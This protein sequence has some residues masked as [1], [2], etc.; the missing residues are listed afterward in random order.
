MAQ[1]GEGKGNDSF[2]NDKGTKEKPFSRAL[3]K[4]RAPMP[5]W[6]TQ[7][8]PKQSSAPR[9]T[10]ASRLRSRRDMLGIC[11]SERCGDCFLQ[12]KPP[13]FKPNAPRL[14]LRRRDNSPVL[15]GLACHFEGGKK[16]WIQPCR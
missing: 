10:V 5:K 13:C 14:L 11:R 9:R 6:S 3:Q 7:R 1:V 16:D 8:V 12:L 4:W 2:A 15:H